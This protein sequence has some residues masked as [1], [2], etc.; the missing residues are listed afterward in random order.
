MAR[1]TVSS[2]GLGII[3]AS[4]FILSMFSGVYCHF[5]A[6][7]S[8]GVGGDNPITMNFGIWYYQGWLLVQNTVQ[9]DVILEGCFNYPDGTSF[10]SKWKSAMAF[11]VITLIMGGVVTFWALMA[12]CLYPSQRAYKAGGFIYMICCLFQGLTLLFLDSNACHDNDLLTDLKEALPNANLTFPSSCSMAAGAKCSIAATV[13][14]FLAAI[15]AVKVDPPQRSPVTVE[16]QDVTYTKTTGEDGI[17]VVSEN[18][19]KGD[20]VVVGEQ[21]EAEQAV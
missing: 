15:A 11:S 21:E 19:V 1:S 12:S 10:D 6:F 4:A 9:G 8:D 14:W 3:A 5:I 18:V 20:P 17:A 7:H 2:A 16:T 13:L